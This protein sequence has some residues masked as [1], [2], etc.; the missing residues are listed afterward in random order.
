MGGKHSKQGRLGTMGT[1]WQAVWVSYIVALSSENCI[2]LLESPIP[3]TTTS[4]KN[5][6][7]Y[8]SEIKIDLLVEKFS[9]FNMWIGLDVFH[10][11]NLK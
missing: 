5:M 3:T 10:Q 9:S 11:I 4:Q 2:Q 7:G 1:V 6:D 8:I